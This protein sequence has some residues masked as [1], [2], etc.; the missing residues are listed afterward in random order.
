[1]LCKTNFSGNNDDK[2]YATGRALKS[3]EK[4]ASIGR[5]WDFRNEK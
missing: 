4:C 2:A 5:N 3:A 1:M